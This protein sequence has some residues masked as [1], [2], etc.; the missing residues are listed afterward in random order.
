M[1][2]SIIY[3]YGK[4]GGGFKSTLKLGA[5]NIPQCKGKSVDLSCSQF[6]QWE[7]DFKFYI[8]KCSALTFTFLATDCALFSKA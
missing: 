7:E 6:C 8:P 5:Y 4:F 1:L 2:A 3:N